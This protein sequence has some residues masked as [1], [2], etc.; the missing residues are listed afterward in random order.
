LRER[1][2]SNSKIAPRSRARPIHDFHHVASF[3]QN[4][5]RPGVAILEAV[6]RGLDP[7]IHRKKQLFSKRMDCRVISAF[8]RVFN[9]VCPAMTNAG[10]RIAPRADGSHV[11]VAVFIVNNNP[12]T[13]E[14]IRPHVKVGSSDKCRLANM[15]PL[16]LMLR[17]IAA[18]ANSHASTVQLRCD[19]SQS[20]RARRPHPS[21]RAHARSCFAASLQHARSSG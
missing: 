18:Q 20:M 9:A 1:T 16:A 12:E 6:M 19:A 3:G 15:S 17:S 14:R 8:T 11:R 4:A 13:R 2:S 21:R 7:R 5:P 10:L